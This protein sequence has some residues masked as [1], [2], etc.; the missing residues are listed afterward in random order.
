[1]KLETVSVPLFLFLLSGCSGLYYPG[2][3]EM[4][5]TWYKGC[6]ERIGGATGSETYRQ[7]ERI[8]YDQSHYRTV[9]GFNSSSCSERVS[10]ILDLYSYQVGPERESNVGDSRELKLVFEKRYIR[11]DSSSEADSFNGSSLC[12]KSNWV[13]GTFQDVTGTTCEPFFP[14]A[15]RRDLIAYD[16]TDGG[17][18][19]L[20]FAPNTQDKSQGFPANIQTENQFVKD[21]AILEDPYG[22]D[23]P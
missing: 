20:V 19:F 18:P 6:H 1:M 17:E 12:G 9:I 7:T 16:E 21:V 4:I 14:G 15:E 11:P 2:V 13:S 22:G 8:F 3:G 23:L 5:G 10:T